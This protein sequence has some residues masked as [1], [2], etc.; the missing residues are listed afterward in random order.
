MRERVQRSANQRTCNTKCTKEKSSEEL[1]VSQK[2]KLNHVV[3]QRA[4]K[5]LHCK[6]TGKWSAFVGVISVSD[7]ELYAQCGVRQGAEPH[8]ERG[9]HL[10]NWPCNCQQLAWSGLAELKP[11]WVQIQISCLQQ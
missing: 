3:F 8:R 2:Y 4:V 10:H 1:K 6:G 7:K 11:L 5:L 9:T